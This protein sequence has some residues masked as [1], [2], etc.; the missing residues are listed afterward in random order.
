MC[1][2]QVCS[3]G[4][5]AREVY[6]VTSGMLQMVKAASFTACS[7]TMTM[8]APTCFGESALLCDPAERIRQ[9]T[10]SALPADQS[11]AHGGASVVAF[12]VAAIEELM[13]FILQVS[14]AALRC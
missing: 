1:G 11:G 10:V 4:D 13:G 8:A 6:A 3:E 12:G 14:G 7:F 9:A 5:T 2:T